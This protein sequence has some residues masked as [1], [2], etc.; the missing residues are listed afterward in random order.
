[1]LQ[2]L[3]VAFLWSTSWVLIKIGLASN[4]PALTFAG[5]RYTLAL[6]VLLI[7]GLRTGAVRRLARLPLARWVWLAGLGIVY[8]AGAQGTQ[9]VALS[10]LPAITVN[11]LLNFTSVMAALFGLIFLA[12]RPTSGQWGG[13]GLTLAGAWVY[14]YP[15]NILPGQGFGIFVALIGALT[16]AVGAILGRAVNRTGDLPP[17][18]VTVASMGVGAP[19]LL[20]TGTLT[21][22]LPS[23]SL[24]SWA[25]VTW[26]AVVN[27]AFAFTL[28][29][30]SQRTLTAFESSTLNNTMLIQIP[31][32]AVLFL[33]E[34]LTLKQGL[35]LVLAGLGT[36]V[37][38][39]KRSAGSRE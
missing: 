26:L 10:Y 32:L 27:T 17:L 4:I 36:W 3:F 2:A 5:L 21:Q 12:E 34:S 22:G 30:L 7:W 38:Q 31:I 20:I 14:F 39:Y 28:W 6:T 15:V 35:G 18:D 19:L 23:L 29:N 9:F 11:L 8:Y 16:N 24:Q 25:I 13:I 33:G 1:M 37:V